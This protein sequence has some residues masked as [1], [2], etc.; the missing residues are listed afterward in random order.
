VTLSGFVLGLVAIMDAFAGEFVSAAWLIILCA[1]IDKLDGMA[2]RLLKATSKIGMQL[3]SFSDL[4]SFGC[5]PA[6]LVYSLAYGPATA[7]DP[8][9]A[10]WHT[11]VTSV[12]VQSMVIAYVL[13]ACIRLAK[14]NVLEEDP[15][16]EKRG[17]GPGVFY[18]IPTT[19]AGGVLA[20][21][22]IIGFEYGAG[23][24]LAWTPVL[25]LVLGALM[26]SNLVLPKVGK[27]D[28]KLLNLWQLSAGSFAYVCGIFRIFPEF[29]M[30]LLV[31]YLVTGLAWGLMNRSDLMPKPS[32]LDPYPP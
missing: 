20:A 23:G 5:A 1:C 9:F 6:A 4:I 25:A 30:G 28:N 32:R 12:L 15:N 21:T 27:Y 2:A 3:D 19:F 14:F 8:D 13:L 31:L 10:L 29:V 22:V 11:P 16:F 7:Q 26:V 17:S 18:G 24:M